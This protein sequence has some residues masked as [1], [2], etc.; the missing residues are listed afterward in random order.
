M[1][2][3]LQIIAATSIV[4][5]VHNRPLKSIRLPCDTDIGPRAMARRRYLMRRGRRDQRR[6]M[7]QIRRNVSETRRRALSVV[8]QRAAA[9]SL[10]RHSCR[11]V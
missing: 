3:D 4:L 5:E 9:H 7:R 6:E 8:S 11:C 10:A 2:A 1:V